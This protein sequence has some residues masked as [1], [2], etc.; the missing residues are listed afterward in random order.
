MLP[1]HSV[2]AGYDFTE[3][4]FV[5]FNTSILLILTPDSLPVLAFLSIREPVDFLS[6]ANTF[7]K[8]LAQ[9]AVFHLRITR[10]HLISLF[11]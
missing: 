7:L 3:N 10:K 2:D 1:I 6:L 4:G 8:F 5:P 11:S 9:S